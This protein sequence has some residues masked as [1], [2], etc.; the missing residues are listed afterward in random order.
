MVIL[1]FALGTVIREQDFTSGSFLEDFHA[2]NFI[3]GSLI[4]DV[5]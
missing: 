3:Q 1:L 5:S 4:S 2:S